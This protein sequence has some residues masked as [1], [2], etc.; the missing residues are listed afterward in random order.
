MGMPGILL[1]CAAALGLAAALWVEGAPAARHIVIVAGKKSHGPEG[2]GIHDYPWSARLLKVMLDRS[3]IAGQVAVSF[4]L[5]GWPKDTRALEAADAIMI[6][7]DGRDGDLYAEAPHLENAE[8]VEFLEKQMKRGCGLLTFHFSTFA[9]DKWAEQSLRWTGGYFDWEEGGVRK[10]YSAIQT[11]EA[12]V[13]P[14]AGAHPVLRGVPAFKLREEFYY[15]IRFAPDDARWTPLWSVPD[16]PG[17]DAAGRVVAWA[18]EREDGGRGFGTTCGHFYD[19]WKEAP[20]RK[21]I[22][23]ALVWAAKVEVPAAGVEAPYF[24]REEIRA[25]LAGVNGE[26]RALSEKP[27]RALILTGHQ[28]PGHKWAETTPVLRAALEQDG[29]FVVEVS[30]DIERLSQIKPGSHDVLV[31]NYCNWEQPRGLSAQSKA[32][33]VDYL[34]AGGGLV[35]IHFANGAWHFSL[36]KAGE[37]DWPEFRNICRRVWDHKSDSGHDPFG[38]FRCEITAAPHAITQGM[39]AFDTLDELYF[40][41]KGTA[42]IEPLVTAKSRQT[43][44]DEPLAWAYDYGRGRVFQTVLG[45]G[46]V[47]LQMAGPA[48]LVR[49]GAAWAAGREQRPVPRAEAQPASNATAVGST[50]RAANPPPVGAAL[51]EGKSGRALD[52]RVAGALVEG[53]E[54]FRK[55]PRALTLTARLFGKAQFNILLA[56]EPKRAP[57]HWELY[58]YAGSGVLSVFLP[59]RGGEYRSAVDICDGQ[60]HELAMELDDARL[61]L[62]VDGKRVLDEALPPAPASTAA[63][64]SL[65]IGRLAE[66]GIGCEGWIDE[67]TFTRPAT[68][69]TPAQILGAWSFDALEQGKR[70]ADRS[71][72]QRFALLSSDAP[73]SGAPVQGVGAA[74]D[75]T[76]QTEK[77]WVDARWARTQMGPFMSGHIATPHGGTAKGIALR[78]GD[79]GEATVCFDTDLLRYS[80]GW[81]GGFLQP[82]ASRY[83]LIHPLK[84][85]GDIVFST[86]KSPG[87][88]D[89]RG[90]FDDLRQ[91]R[92]GPLPK[93]WARHRALHLHG[94]RL[95]LAASVDGVEILDSPW[96]HRREGVVAITREWEAGPRNRPLTVHLCDMAKARIEKHGELSVALVALGTQVSAVAIA[97]GGALRVE[98]PGRVRLEFAVGRLPLRA[99]A[100]FWRG[101]ANEL[102]GFLALARDQSAPADLRKWTAAGPARWGAPLQTRGIVDRRRTAFAID[103]IT[104]PH[105]NPFHALMFTAG[106]DFF[107]NGDAAVCTVH[108]DVW[109]VSGLDET[110]EGVRWQRYATGLYQPLGLRVVNDRVHVLGRDQITR[111]VDSNADGEADHYEVFNNDLMIGGGGHSYATSLETDAQGRFYFMRCA[112]DTPHGGVALRV[113]KDGS[114]LE[115]LSTGFRNPNG[116]GVGPDGTVTAADQQGDWVPETRLDVLRPGGF[117]GFMPMHK[118]AEA[119]QTFDAPLCWIPRALDNSAGGQ[120]WVPDGKWGALGGQMLHLSYGRCTWMMVLRDGA[121]GAVVPLPGKFLSGAMRG[122]FSPRDGHFYVSG[123]RGWQTAA[124][125]DGCLQRVRHTG[126]PLHLPVATR[127]SA[128]GIRI[129]FNTPLDKKAAVDAG[130]WALE[131]WNYRWSST[132]GSKDWSVKNPA[133]AGRDPV[134]VRRA[135][136]SADGRTV[137]LRLEG[138]QKVHVLS[139]QYNLDSADGANFKGQ[140]SLTINQV[141]GQ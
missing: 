42:P 131:Q 28:Y 89:G 21:F 56:S 84:P 118:R 127:V 45:H 27:I 87:W 23:N 71:P 53:H 95:V 114:K 88:A 8:R 83:G 16:L 122:R 104:V 51:V 124:V 90:R 17:R 72:H 130:N 108:G 37:S 92:F 135:E 105:E 64:G 26:Q 136:L 100:F 133:Q 58:T 94:N 6:I 55:G 54:D 97:G 40:R 82:D 129:T 32:A 123:L 7:S 44:R 140:L 78:V 20:F 63:D 117:Y 39:A 41:Q 36:P 76:R 101:A 141:P 120:A 91:P 31:L 5:D 93:D 69:T 67:V 62:F 1:R 99:K 121:N 25:A 10:W 139:V 12:Q 115:V 96:A 43:G 46:A 2:N 75:P 81:T 70:F 132:Y 60:W 137:L 125:R 59:G 77:D 19:N 73:P 38:A 111:L 79:Q 65:A 85:V 112:E 15:N 103:T 4:H 106:H 113:D 66:G 107:S 11:R 116:M 138:V 18:R 52:A 49:R 98:E 3:N 109:R 30:E 119:P 22:L 102:P 80:A 13:Q 68:A 50:P 86:E 35:L 33:F 34:K 48:E 14:A 47:S 110:L 29:C 61:R 126:E 24:S 57:R 74:D 9:P 134:E 128:D